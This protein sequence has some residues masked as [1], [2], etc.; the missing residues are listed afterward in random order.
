MPATVQ[1]PPDAGV[2]PF[3]DL[4]SG[5]DKSAPEFG[6]FTD[7]VPK[8][9]FSSGVK[10][11]G[12]DF[13]QFSDLVP[14]SPT[15]ETE[16]AVADTPDTE[17]MSDLERLVVGLPPKKPAETSVFHQT[18]NAV[19]SLAAGA[20]KYIY[21][22]LQALKDTQ[23]QYLEDT[24]TS[25][26]QRADYLKLPDGSALSKEQQVELEKKYHDAAIAD[27]PDA[28]A[29]ADLFKQ[30]ASN[31]DTA[32]YVDPALANTIPAR[33]AHATGQASVMAVESLIPRI[34]VPL[35]V[36][37]GA[38]ATQSEYQKAH[39]DAPY[40]EAEDAG[41]RSAIGLALFGGA[42]KL[43]A[44]GVAKMLPE[45]AGPMQ[46]FL[47]QFLGQADANMTSSRAINAWEAA[48][49]AE[50]GKKIE[51][52]LNA[53]KDTTLEQSTLNIVYALAHAGKAAG[54]EPI[55]PASASESE[56]LPK[57]PESQPATVG[58]PIEQ[59]PKAEVLKPD[60]ERTAET[61]TTPEWFHGTHANLEQLNPREI[62]SVDSLGTWVTGS[63]EKARE[64]YGP[65]V[66]GV[67]TTN[68][69]RFLEF[70]GT[71]PS[72][73][74][75][76]RI[77]GANR[78][79]A[80]E[81]G[82]EKEANVLEN[83]I[84][85][86]HRLWELS[87]KAEE[88]NGLRGTELSEYRSLVAADNASEKLLRSPKY[89]A[90]FRKM[91]EDAGYDGIRWKDS[92]IDLRSTDNPH[93]VAV[94]FHKEPLQFVKEQ[95]GQVNV[96]K[97]IGTTGIGGAN[98][99]SIANGGTVSGESST[100][101]P[102]ARGPGELRVQPATAPAD[103]SGRTPQ[104]QAEPVGV[105]D[106]I[107]EIQRRN[108]PASTK[109]ATT[110]AERETRGI[111]PAEEVARRDFGTV[112][113]EA[114][115]ITETDPTAPERLAQEVA[116]NPRTLSDKENALLLRRQ[117]EVQN[118]HNAAINAVNEAP[119]ESARMDASV[120]L[121][122]ARDNLQV[123]YDATNK[124]GT[125]TAR[126][127][128][129]RKMLAN[130]DFS[131][132][133]M[134]AETR[135]VINEGKP[136]NAKQ[137]AEV[138]VLHE[139]IATA[140][141]KV[142]A[143]EAREQ[144]ETELKKAKAQSRQKG[145]QPV[146]FLE[147]QAQR[148]RERIAARRGRLYSDPLGV[149]Q[150]AHLADEAIIGA[151]HI[152]KGVTKF[153]DWSAK[154]IAEFG[155]R[156]RP[157]LQALFAKARELH[158]KAQTSQPLPGRADML[159]RTAAGESRFERALGGD[160]K[161]IRSNIAKLESKTE[162]GDFTQPEKQPP[163]MDK[164]KA[165]LL[166][167]Y[168]KA[169]DAYNKGLIEAKLR[170]QS[171]PRKVLRYGGEALNTTR[172]IMTSFDLSAVLRQGGFIAFGHPIR[173]LQAFPDMLRALRSEESQFR[174]ME[175]IRNRPNAPLYA[176]AKL[177]I[178]DQGPG[179]KLSQM[180]EQYMSRW[181]RRIPGVGASE[182]AYTTF[183]NRLR[184][185]S[186]DTMAENLGKHGKVTIEEAKAIANYV[187]VATGRGNLDGA[188]KAA[189]VFNTLFFS[190]RYVVSRFQ[191]LAGQPFYRGTVR[192]RTL[193]A[194]EY[195]RT[196]AGAA[197]VYA[198]GQAAGA[199]ISTDPTSPDFGK[200]KFGNTRVDPLFGL[201]QA[202]VFLSREG[203]A[204]RRFLTQ[205]QSKQPK[206]GSGG[207]VLAR[208]LRSKLSPVVGSAVDILSGKNVVG[209][210]VTPQSVGQQIMVPLS[211][212]DVYNAMKE[213]GIVRGTAL[214]ILALFGMGIQ[215][216][217]PKPAKNTSRKTYRPAQ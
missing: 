136:L 116:T 86:S 150:V 186:F 27:V 203:L 140:E 85:D 161:R 68:D 149:T 118:E 133:K 94:I 22:G 67:E 143:Y 30:L 130:N 160:K 101:N 113:D 214:G 51:T 187:N 87:R 17:K 2:D 137:A 157:H 171:I 213:Q 212:G 44:L 108:A 138:K 142:S 111:A 109:N 4:I 99:P 114:K 210:K 49:E 215:N 82:F 6:A 175:D 199:T 168:Q 211:F 198:L 121:E 29:Q 174:V 172:A 5:G 206:Y 39:P 151:S 53:L 209:Q 77:I 123:V 88:G 195:A 47:T 139:R 145:F 65:N 148:A 128:N 169:K 18:L 192:T 11:A 92:K 96:D 119:N 176:Q 216:Y 188:A 127:L 69:L 178:S 144:F 25:A 102:V 98:E 62:K 59:A 7:L 181:A 26:E 48:N 204:L 41:T 15:S 72:Q 54:K 112:W 50:P 84:P 103:I 74:D 78:H 34:G 197:V 90:L 83:T 73:R 70:D 28:K 147:Q 97:R 182:R 12:A 117:I 125:E 153:T 76:N 124:A 122:R 23:A 91:L 35:M 13:G 106:A 81:A 20:G 16:K 146:S 14:Q 164:Q 63:A 105:A 162:A 132:A 1:A 110:F 201:T 9:S 64:L 37:H 152:A 45:G 66:H 79:L 202:S 129:A 95:S 71:I 58:E 31:T 156:I 36:Y 60:I 189:T 126:G 93:T 46:R 207:E 56:I 24:A 55:R 57:T 3:S 40:S 89:M 104:A 134:E 194:Q 185:D 165:A 167:E 10:Q 159:S 100:N 193:V 180:E 52:A 200:L 155:E 43:A 80:R 61:P 170:Q 120:R 166:F 8:D 141:A 184:A 191:L 177:Y 173:A 75:F 19:R 163:R 205:D 217:S 158:G 32:L 196:L 154:M 107:A 190:P 135:A 21:E 179:V 131:L 115:A 183:L 33:L 42:S 38:L 208:F